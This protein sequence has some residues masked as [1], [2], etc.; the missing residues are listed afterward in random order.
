MSFENPQNQEKVEALAYISEKMS[1][2]KPDELRAIFDEEFARES[3]IDPLDVCPT[4][5]PSVSGEE[6]NNLARSIF[7]AKQNGSAQ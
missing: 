7:E 6:Y 1:L 4:S 3:G 5:N 2:L